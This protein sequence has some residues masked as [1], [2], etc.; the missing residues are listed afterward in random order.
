MRL[1][2]LLCPICID[3]DARAEVAARLAGKKPKRRPFD[4]ARWRILER[5]Q[6][7]EDAEPCAG[8]GGRQWDVLP[9]LR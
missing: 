6:T 7:V 4:S 9:I 3:K 1:G 5:G 2:M 8:C